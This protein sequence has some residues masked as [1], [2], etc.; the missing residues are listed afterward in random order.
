M[1]VN[2]LTYLTNKKQLLSTGSSQKALSGIHWALR[3]SGQL[4]Y[5]YFLCLKFVQT[6]SLLSVG[7]PILDEYGHTNQTWWLGSGE[8]G[9]NCL[10]EFKH[11]WKSQWQ[12][13]SFHRDFERE[14][15]KLPWCW[16]GLGH[17]SL[18]YGNLAYWIFYTQGI[19]ESGKNRKVTLIL[20]HPPLL[21][22]KHFCKGCPLYILRKGA[23]LPPKMKEC[24]E[25]SE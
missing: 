23:S 3:A 13:A 18:K 8:Q 17:T 5:F 25:W 14:G 10:S 4:S 24:Q 16:W 22:I 15:I 19:C 12:N 6:R 9:W 1:G 21:M 11:L 20:S 2:F 7:W